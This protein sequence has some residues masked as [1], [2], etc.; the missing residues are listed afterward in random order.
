MEQHLLKSWLEKNGI[1]RLSI[2]REEAREKLLQHFSGFCPDEA[3]K[4]ISKILS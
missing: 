2:S 4:K 1:D 3:M